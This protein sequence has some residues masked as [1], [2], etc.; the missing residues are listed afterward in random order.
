MTGLSNIYGFV[1]GSCEWR[2]AGAAEVRW[3]FVEQAKN[4]HVIVWLLL[5][6]LY[7]S[8]E[9]AVRALDGE[10]DAGVVYVS[11]PALS[12]A[13][14]GWRRGGWFLLTL[15]SAKRAVRGVSI[16]P[17]CRSSRTVLLLAWVAVRLILAEVEVNYL[18][19]VYA[20]N[21]SAPGCS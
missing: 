2:H 5:R 8:V 1:G 13:T 4:K 10:V 16:N 15:W 19:G 17:H 7:V 20:W 18:H 6:A 9:R 11:A 21:I 3:P 14:F 12:F